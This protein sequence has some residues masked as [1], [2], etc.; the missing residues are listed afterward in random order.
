MSRRAIQTLAL[1]ALSFGLVS[2][3]ASSAVWGKFTKTG[4]NAGNT[5]TAATD[6]T[7][8]V[9]TDTT[10]AKS[11]GGAGGVIKKGGTYYVYA[12]VTD[13]GN[14]ASGVN[15]V[16][17][18]VNTITSGQ[19]AASLTSGSYEVE[20]VAYNRRSAKLTAGSSLAAGTY[21]YT[22]TMKD[23][24]G[25][26]RAESGFSVEVDNT[27]MTATN[28]QITNGSTTAGLAQ[29][30]DHITFTFS[31]EP[32]PASILAGWDGTSTA[33]VVRLNQVSAA[34]TVTIYNSTN[35]TA[36]PLGTIELGRT[37]YTTSSRTFGA[38]GTDSTMELSGNQLFITLGTQSGAATTAAGT[39]TLKWTPSA[40][41]TDIAGNAMS[42]A[43]KSVTGQKAF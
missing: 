42:T 34:D 9:A 13:G 7:A 14:P 22:L 12:N 5:I 23:V 28:I 43:A 1:A 35:T 17:A 39:G 3:L 19:N 8:P 15:T 30:G 11:A 16:T 10:I 21:S 18:N 29:L 20:G 4:S 27:A 36:L 38:S 25:N 2:A 37:D 24:A 33:V 41:V 32:D 40:T 6:F 26:S 31:E